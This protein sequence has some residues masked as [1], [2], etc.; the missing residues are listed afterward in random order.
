MKAS[1]GSL[2]LT[3]TVLVFAGIACSSPREFSNVESP[4]LIWSCEPQKILIGQWAINIEADGVGLKAETLFKPEVRPDAVAASHKI[5]IVEGELNDGARVYSGADFSFVI[6]PNQKP[7]RNPFYNNN[8]AVAAEAI[9]VKFGD[10]AVLINR[11]YACVGSASFF[12]E[13]D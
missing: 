5:E 2:I 3:L 4:I 6:Y 1:G 13:S 11:P 9:S 10:H 12:S 7:E 8:S